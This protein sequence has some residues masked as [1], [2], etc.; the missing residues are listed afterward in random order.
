MDPQNKSI[1]NV[2]IQE[3]KGLHP[4]LLTQHI[5]GNI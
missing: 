2:L 1:V 4:A 5:K 3:V